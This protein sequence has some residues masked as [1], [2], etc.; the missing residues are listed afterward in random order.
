LSRQYEAEALQLD[1]NVAD[2]VAAPILRRHLVLVFVDRLDLA[3]ARAI[4]YARTLMPDELRAVH[5]ALDE[6]RAAE[7]AQAWVDHG[8]SR[9]ALDLADCPDRR[10][11][12]A[13][14]GLG[15]PGVGGGQTAGR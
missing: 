2:A 3:A 5:F 13:A 4:Q 15:A 9:I 12:Q 10:L 6:Q 1:D 11:S 8:M 7:I 14:V